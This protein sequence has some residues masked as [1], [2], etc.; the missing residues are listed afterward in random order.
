LDRS[1]RAPADLAQEATDRPRMIPDAE[2]LVDEAGHATTR[3]EG[4]PKAER[5]SALRQQ[6][7]KLC[8][9]SWAQQGGRTRGRMGTQRCRA[10][11]RG[12]FEPLAD[13]TL[14]HAQGFG[15][16]GLR[17]SHLVQFPRTEAATFAPA[18]W[19]LRICCAHA[20]EHST[21]RP[22]IIRSLCADQ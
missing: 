6:L 17:P 8:E 10:V 2:L 3:P 18:Q 11:Q 19:L 14:C 12:A 13:R 16:A 5:F 22:M 20:G 4:A 7:L 9:L 15:D 21:L 1:L